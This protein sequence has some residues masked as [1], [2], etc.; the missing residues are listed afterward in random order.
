[1]SSKENQ[2]TASLTKLPEPTQ[3][4]SEGLGISAGQQASLH[5]LLLSTAGASPASASESTAGRGVTDSRAHTQP[6]R[7]TVR[8]EKQRETQCPL[9]RPRLSFCLLLL[10]SSLPSDTPESRT[11]IFL[12]YCQPA[13]SGTAGARVLLSSLTVTPAPPRA[14]SAWLIW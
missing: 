7:R 6:L 4:W 10:H 12:I 8:T 13:P 14:P 2:H 11:S 9:P 5:L 1:M 3:L